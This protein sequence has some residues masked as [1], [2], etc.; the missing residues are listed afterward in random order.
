MAADDGRG[1]QWLE[2]GPELDG[3]GGWLEVDADGVPIRQLERRDGE[4]VASSWLEG[5]LGEGIVTAADDQKGI[6]EGMWRRMASSDFDALWA[7][8]LARKANHWSS[9]KDGVRVGAV[10][11]ALVLRF[12]PQGVICDI[13]T[14]F[15]AVIE[16]GE[17]DGAGHPAQIRHTVRAV[18]AGFDDD[19][20]RIR[21]RLEP[22][23]PSN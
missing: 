20:Q 17:Y 15:A 2:W 14:K 1:R 13:G 3:I 8:A 23:D 10:V 16:H 21:L 4:L 5:I 9:V 19:S 12:E 7:R 22:A 6:D 11:D 18:V